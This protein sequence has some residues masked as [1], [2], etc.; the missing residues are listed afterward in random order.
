M[1]LH[2]RRRLLV[3]INDLQGEVVPLEQAEDYA[4]RFVPVDAVLV[5]GP[6]RNARMGS[7][8]VVFWHESFEDVPQNALVPAKAVN[9][10]FDW[11]PS[12]VK[13]E[14]GV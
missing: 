14:G 2:D 11:C 7:V 5:D 13:G 9:W 8:D 1:N 10:D 3:R 4:R 12:H 6:D